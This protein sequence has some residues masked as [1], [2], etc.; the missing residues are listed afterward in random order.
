[1][2]KEEPKEASIGH[3]FKGVLLLKGAKKWGSM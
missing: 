3:S 2:G 1:M